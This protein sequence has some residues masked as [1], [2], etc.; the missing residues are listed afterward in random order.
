MTH[1]REGI[2][3]AAVAQKRLKTLKQMDVSASVVRKGKQLA[4]YVGSFHE[5]ARATNFAEVLKQKKIEVTQIR[6]KAE[7][8]GKI[9]TTKPLQQN[10]ATEI[11]AELKTAHL[12]VTIFQQ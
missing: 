9:L 7:L 5:E 2:Y 3:P 4:V 12:P 10:V 8:S 1:L 11:A 6:A